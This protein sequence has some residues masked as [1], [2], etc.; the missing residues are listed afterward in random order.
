M[1][2]SSSFHRLLQRWL[3]PALVSLVAACGGGGGDD[4]GPVDPT[5]VD[6]SAAAVDAWNAAI[7]DSIAASGTTING[8]SE[9]TL[10]ALAS[11]AV[12]DALNAIDAR[13]A[14]R[15]PNPAPL[16]PAAAPA[17]A[18]ARAAHDVLQAYLPGARSLLDTRLAASLAALP[19]GNP[20]DLGEQVGAAAAARVIAARGGAGIDEVR[21]F[22]LDSVSQFRVAPPYG[23]APGTPAQVAAAAT[24]TAAYA[25]DYNEVRCLGRSNGIAI[26]GCAERSADQSEIATYWVESVT[27]GWN[28]IATVVAK[29]AG[30]EGWARARLYAWLHMALTDS[31]F[32][33][34]DSK[35]TYDFWRP[36]VA[37]AQAGSD[38]NPATDPVPG[39]TPVNTTPASTDYPSAHASGG[40]AAAAVLEAVFPAGASFSMTSSS[41]GGATRRFTGFDAAAAE[42]A[43]S[44]IYVGFHFRHSTEVGRAL[45]RQ[46]GDWTVGQTLAA[47]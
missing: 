9:L 20:R 39:W 12:H 27:L 46:V 17:A 26:A 18:V 8:G 16:E 29:D 25:T 3:L 10:Y 32:A 38:G 11:L 28:R 15:Y 30:L 31:Q 42:N 19:A 40:D 45:G 35:N 34:S 6:T 2:L 14:P 47:R 5:P 37:I 33:T 44:R 24:A 7:G 4:A 23:V 13:Y 43:V 21:T 36:V 22:A 41:G 1:T